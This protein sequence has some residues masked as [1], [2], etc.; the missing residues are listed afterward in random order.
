MGGVALRLVCPR[1]I[2]VALDRVLLDLVLRL[3]DGIAAA[4]EET[5]VELAQSTRV[6]GADAD[7]GERDCE[8]E[9]EQRVQ[10]PLAAPQPHEE[11][12]LVRVAA[13]AVPPPAA[14]PRRLRRLRLSL[15]RLLLCLD[16]R[17]CHLTRAE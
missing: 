12:L 17:A 9:R 7:A 6:A 2:E 13:A 8:D 14:P 5:G 3:R 10:P 4:A 15:L 11:E 16:R 1:E